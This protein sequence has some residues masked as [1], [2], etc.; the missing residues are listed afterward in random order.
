M[1]TVDWLV[2]S[3]GRAANDGSMRKTGHTK[4]RRHQAFLYLTFFFGVNVFLGFCLKAGNL[5]VGSF[6]GSRSIGKEMAFATRLGTDLFWWPWSLAAAVVPAAAIAWRRPAA[7]MHLVC[8]L[9][10]VLVGMLI[11]V[12]VGYILP[13]VSVPTGLMP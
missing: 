11:L 6:L 4:A 12:V 3:T 1:V 13:F 5:Y 8:A 10:I 9:L 7:A 2:L